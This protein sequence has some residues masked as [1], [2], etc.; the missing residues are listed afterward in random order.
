MNGATGLSKIERPRRRGR[1]PWP[2][3][4]SVKRIVSMSELELKGPRVIR[5]KQRGP[6]RRH[7]GAR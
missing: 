4:F 1:H 7:G 6:E 5:G 2:F 3:A